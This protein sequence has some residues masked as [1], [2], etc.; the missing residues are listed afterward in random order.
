MAHVTV[1]IP[2]ELLQRIDQVASAEN[3]TPGEWLVEL[4]RS[5]LADEEKLPRWERF[6]VQRAV[7]DIREIA[8]EDQGHN[9]DST[10]EIRLMR[11][12][13]R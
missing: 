10:E 9:W 11:E 5:R 12:S 1:S 7:R 13:R 8:S 3:Q 6:S 4:V 2:D